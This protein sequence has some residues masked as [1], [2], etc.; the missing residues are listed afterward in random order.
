[1]TLT[2]TMATG[3]PAAVEMSFDPPAVP[4]A[5]NDPFAPSGD[6]PTSAT[7]QEVTAAT[8]E[9]LTNAPVISPTP[10]VLQPSPSPSPTPSPTK[11][12]TPSV[13]A[14][15]VTPQHK[16]ASAVDDLLGMDLSGTATTDTTEP[17]QTQSEAIDIPKVQ[18][19]SQT[20]LMGSSPEMMGFQGMQQQ[21]QGQFG[22]MGSS[23]GGTMMM[24]QVP[25]MQQQMM[26]G[27]G[28]MGTSPGSMM[29]MGGYGNM[30]QQGMQ[31]QAVNPAD[32]PKRVLT[33]GEKPKPRNALDAL[34]IGMC[35]AFIT[36]SPKKG[37]S[38][39]GSPAHSGASDTSKSRQ[40]IV[41]L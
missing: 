21:Q 22:V 6:L 39:T 27:M 23:P 25:M 8:E 41:V 33:R 40:I 31:Q 18:P 35:S 9:T 38:T 3:Q 5:Q 36:G 34:D 37:G 2:A 11:Q 30:M 26:P 10:A 4:P 19:D 15:P 14:Q 29:M 28:M 20:S 16:P 1:M 7:D 17:P 24:G 13:A 12:L 32:Q